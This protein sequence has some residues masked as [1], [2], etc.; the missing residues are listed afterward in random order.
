MLN[1]VFLE[2]P[3]SVDESYGAHLRAALSFAMVML[4]CSLAATVHA[5]LPCLFKS[6]ASKTIAQLHDTMNARARKSGE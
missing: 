2:H 6:T 1:R 4:A 3:H 5:V